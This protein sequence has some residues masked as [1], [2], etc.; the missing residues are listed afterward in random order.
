MM[1]SSTH[2]RIR[3]LTPMAEELPQ[4]IHPDFV[5]RLDPEYIAFHNAHI[6]PLPALH[7]LPWDPAVRNGINVPGSRPAE[8][9][10]SIKDYSLTH[11]KVRAL[12]PKG[13]APPGGWPVYIW[14]HGG[15]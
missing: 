14:Y 8:E 7:T 12:V 15:E 2:T 3:Q 6:A 4:A 9:V 10:G 11:C 13:E 1:P 5:H